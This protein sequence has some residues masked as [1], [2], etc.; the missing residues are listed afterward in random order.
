[1]ANVNILNLLT[2]DKEQG[3]NQTPKNVIII[4]S[5]DVYNDKVLS[6]LTSSSKETIVVNLNGID[7][8]NNAKKPTVKFY[9][10]EKSEL[11]I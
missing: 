3:F 6:Y 1:M 11:K 2:N 5:S 7:S 9:F 10:Q 8:M 4:A